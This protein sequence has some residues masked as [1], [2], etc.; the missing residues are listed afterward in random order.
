MTTEEIIRDAVLAYAAQ[1]MER[2]LACC[3][4]YAIP[5]CSELPQN[6]LHI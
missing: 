4:E 5:F 1:D 6:A 3:T 2:V